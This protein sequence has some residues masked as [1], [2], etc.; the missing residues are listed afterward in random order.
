V[1]EEVAIDFAKIMRAE[2]LLYES[3][4]SSV[5]RGSMPWAIA[6]GVRSA[7][8][9]RGRGHDR[10][11]ERADV[12][13]IALEERQD[14]TLAEARLILAER[15]IRTLAITAGRARGDLHS[16]DDVRGRGGGALGTYD[17]LRAS[18]RAATLLGP[19]PE[20]T[21]RVANWLR[22]EALRQAR[23]S[24]IAGAVLATTRPTVLVGADDIDAR[25]RWFY[26]FAERAGV[27]TLRV[28]FGLSSDTAEWR[29]GIAH[30][31]AVH[32][33]RMHRLLEAGGVP[34]AQ[35]FE[36]GQPRFAGLD[37]LALPN[38]RSVLFV[39]QPFVEG[40]FRT[41]AARREL[42]RS[43]GAVLMSIAGSGLRVGVRPH[44]DESPAVLATQLEH[45]GLRPSAYRMHIEPMAR[46]VLSRY[47]TVVGMFS[48]LL[49][50]ALLAHRR[51]VRIGS[52]AISPIA[53]EFDKM[54]LPVLFSDV[55]AVVEGPHVVTADLPL[56]KAWLRDEFGGLPNDGT[57]LA[58]AI[59]MLLHGDS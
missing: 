17:L 20:M 49:I 25:A 38:D 27:R 11:R 13:F 57:A 22:S 52:A 6:R 55:P 39:S 33:P 50:E 3:R 1:T 36:V 7:L 15:G 40:A 32:G 51:V 10:E 43:V 5:F 19:P 18:G 44:P 42:L 16:A 46:E 41:E 45:G 8:T 35:I 2:Y 21:S 9:E 30:W 24:A 59:T 58:D 31:K 14:P 56:V 53:I 12:L 34:S 28:Q 48:A 37:S 4:R 23:W 47:G 29:P 54:L 26:E